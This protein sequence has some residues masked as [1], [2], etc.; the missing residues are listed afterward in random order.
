LQTLL[1]RRK[2][3]R[4]M[5][6]KREQKAATTLQTLLRRRK[7]RRAMHQKCE[8]KAATTL[9]TLLRRRWARAEYNERWEVHRDERN[10]ATCLQV[11]FESSDSL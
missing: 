4:A 1:R 11:C 9:Q 10:A 8:Q 3:R 6:Q 7:Q 2:Q 5:H